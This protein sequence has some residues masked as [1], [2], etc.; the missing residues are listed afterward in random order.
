[1]TLAFGFLFFNHK[2]HKGLHKEAQ[3]F[4]LT[5]Y[6]VQCSLRFPYMFP[7]CIRMMLQQTQHDLGFWVLAFYFFNLKEHKGL[8]KEAQSF[9]PTIYKVQCS[10][11]FPYMF[12]TCVR[13][14]LQQTQ[15]DICFWVLTFYFLL[16]PFT[17][18]LFY[19][20]C[21]CF[22]AAIAAL[23]PCY[24]LAQLLHHLLHYHLYHKWF[25]I[26]CPMFLHRQ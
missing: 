12:P 3:G 22:F 8:H 21:N 24:R 5:T 7:A 18:L 11:R 20:T 14:I 9:L 16:L 19:S 2:E 4:L 23:Y 10:L 25:L 17:L 6:K 15:H 13:L 1:M 26:A